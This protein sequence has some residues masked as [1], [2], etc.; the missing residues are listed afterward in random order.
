MKI[1]QALYFVFGLLTFYVASALNFYKLGVPV[2]FL[3]IAGAVA[4]GFIARR[5]Q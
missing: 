5:Q 2:G 1:I 4:L 3:W